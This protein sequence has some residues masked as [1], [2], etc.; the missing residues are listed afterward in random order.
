MT[1]EFTVT[2]NPTSPN[3][4]TRTSTSSSR[5]TIRTNGTVTI[6]VVARGVG[7][8]LAVAVAGGGTTIA[9]GPSRWAG[10]PLTRSR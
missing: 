7:G 2:F 9:F 6:P 5:A 4:R 10:S 8:R 1:A 3:I